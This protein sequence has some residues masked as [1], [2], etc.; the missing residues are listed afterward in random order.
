ME[1]PQSEDPQAEQKTI[2]AV[3]FADSLSSFGCSM[4]DRFIKIFSSAWNKFSPNQEN[5]NNQMN[6]TARISDFIDKKIRL[7]ER[8]TSLV[9]YVVPDFK[10]D[11]IIFDS[12]MEIDSAFG[13]QRG[14]TKFLDLYTAQDITGFIQNSKLGELLSQG[15]FKDWYIELDLSDCFVHY[16]YMRLKS[17]PEKEKFIGFLIAQ[18]GPLRLKSAGQN[19]TP[20]QKIVHSKLPEDLNM[21]NIRW[22][23]LQNPFAKFSAKRPR[24]PGQNYPGTGLAREAYNLLVTLSKSAKRDGIL[25]VPEHFHNAFLYEN[26]LF[27]DPD[28]QGMFEKMSEDLNKDINER[29]L[30]AVSWAIY[31]GFLR[32][33]EEVAKWGQYEQVLPLSAKLE[34]Y[35]QSTDYKNEVLAAKQRRGK[36]HILWEEAESYCLSAIISFSGDDVQKDK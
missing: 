27:L 12:D 4:R 26:F 23:A 6:F 2:D 35:F 17:L 9:D 32:C 30:A 11:D 29:G 3:S 36:Y 10:P 16:A 33:D 18:K 15:P 1:D 21:L 13:S 19:E 34:R 28:D 31:F 5:D 22:F 8:L 14:G 7:R 20:G 24:L 25:N